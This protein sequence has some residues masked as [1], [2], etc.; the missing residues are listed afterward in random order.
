[1]EDKSNTTEN[2][3]FCNWVRAYLSE[4]IDADTF[5]TLVILNHYCTEDTGNRDMLVPVMDSVISM[6]PYKPS[7]DRKKVK[8][9]LKKLVEAF[10]Q[11]DKTKE[12]KKEDIEEIILAVCTICREAKESE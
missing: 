3:N 2:Y 6:L 1:M 4:K 11:P 10:N 8:E 7:D 9:Q 12:K 5:A